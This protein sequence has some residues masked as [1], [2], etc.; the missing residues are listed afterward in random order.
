MRTL[1]GLIE[2]AD[3]TTGG[4]DKLDPSPP[5][6]DLQGDESDSQARQGTL[7]CAKPWHRREEGLVMLKRIGITVAATVLA[8]FVAASAAQAQQVSHSN[9]TFSES[10]DFPTGSICDFNLRQEFTATV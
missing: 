5:S 8:T 3:G 9:F 6:R 10:N 2:A 4:L 1:K 7:A